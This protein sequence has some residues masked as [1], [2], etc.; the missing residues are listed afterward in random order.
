M[1]S[2]HNFKPLLVD[3]LEFLG[4]DW[5][6][7]GNITTCED[8]YQIGPKGLD[9]EPFLDDVSSLGKRS[10][11]FQNDSLEWSNVSH[12]VHLIECHDVLFK[13]FLDI[14]DVSSEHAGLNILVSFNFELAF[15]PEL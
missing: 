1:G 10:D 15:L 5:H 11:L 9:L 12:S 7:L 4:L 2:L 8:R 3:T 14:L 6:L 13:L